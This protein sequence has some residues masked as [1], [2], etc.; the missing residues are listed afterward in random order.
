MLAYLLPSRSQS[1]WIYQAVARW[2]QLGKSPQ[3]IQWLTDHEQGNLSAYG[4]GYTNQIGNEMLSEIWL[5]E[6]PKNFKALASAI[7][8]EL[9]H[10][11]SNNTM[12]HGLYGDL[13]RSPPWFVR[14][15]HSVESDMIA[16]S[17]WMISVSRA[18][19][20]R[21]CPLSTKQP[22]VISVGR[23]RGSPPACW[24]AARRWNGSSTS[25][26]SAPTSAAASLPTPTATTTRSTSFVSLARSFASAWK[27]WP[28][29]T[30]CPLI[31]L[32]KPEPVAQLGVDSEEHCSAR[33]VGKPPEG[34]EDLAGEAGGRPLHPFKLFSLAS[35]V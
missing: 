33:P 17:N 19:D 2:K 11:T 16:M 6:C 13:S 28:S 14:D 34:K 1:L 20:G 32:R 23:Y 22:L 8:H 29:S 3:E 10:N 26:R 27:P 7:F 25:T 24:R 15:D 21:R 5:D 30:H 35:R 4:G 12:P 31:P 18:V 9:M